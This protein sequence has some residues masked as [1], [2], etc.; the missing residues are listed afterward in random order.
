M[1]FF[2]AAR[3][4]SAGKGVAADSW[5]EPPPVAEAR[6][7]GES[8]WELWNQ[9][10]ERMDLA[11]APTQPSE[12]TP[13]PEPARDPLRGVPLSAAALMVIARRNN[14]V[15]PQ[16][17]RWNE[18]YQRVGGDRYPD[19]APPP[20]HPAIWTRLS[21]M[22]RRLHFRDHIEWAERR[23]KLPEFAA[24]IEQLEEHDW[25]HMGD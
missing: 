6:E 16:P 4:P 19:L 9:A 13:L 8:T 23:R 12:F 25:V 17:A 21:A 7:G 11:F 3:T 24:F 5:L 20:V 2:R 22:Q 10:S 14:R 1:A 18:L 15:C